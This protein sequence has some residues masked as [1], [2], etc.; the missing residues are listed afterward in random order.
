MDDGHAAQGDGELTGDALETSMVTVDVVPE[1]SIGTPRAEN[2]EY[3]ISIG[4][5]GS[6][7]Q[8]F[9]RATTEMSRWL[10]VD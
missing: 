8:A 10:E 4:S 3:P 6:V 1:K 2:S 9:Q 7:D 5:G